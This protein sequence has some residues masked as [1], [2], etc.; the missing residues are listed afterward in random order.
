MYALGVTTSAA[1]D[2]A[3]DEVTVVGAVFVGSAPLIFA[4]SSAAFASLKF[5]LGKLQLSVS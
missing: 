4:P 2:P 1:A 3:P 5:C